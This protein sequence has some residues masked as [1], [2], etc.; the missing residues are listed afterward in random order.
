MN[1]TFQTEVYLIMTMESYKFVFATS[2]L[3]ISHPFLTPK[4]ITGFPSLA[5]YG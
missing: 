4:D 2:I 5:I 3:K 1:G